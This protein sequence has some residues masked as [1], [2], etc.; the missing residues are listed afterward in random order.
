MRKSILGGPSSRE[1]D[2]HP[3]N[4]PTPKDYAEQAEARRADAD[5]IASQCPWALVRRHPEGGYA[6]VH[7]FVE[8]TTIPEVEPDVH[9]SFVTLQAAADRAAQEGYWSIAPECYRPPVKLVKGL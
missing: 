3:V 6:V 2:E 4:V 5:P 9:E 7:G 1:E 8:D